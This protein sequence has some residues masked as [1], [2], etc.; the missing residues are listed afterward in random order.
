[1][2]LEQALLAAL[3]ATSSALVWAV[4]KLW[5]KSEECESDRRAMRRE[6]E[7]LK[8]D[9]GRAEGRLEA[10]KACPSGSCPFAEQQK[11]GGH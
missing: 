1:M 5:A 8:S 6:I 11:I 3:S 4:T 9:H 7:E 2:T 10:F